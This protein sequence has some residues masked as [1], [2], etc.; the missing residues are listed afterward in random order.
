[1]LNLILIR[2]RRPL[3]INFNLLLFT[4]TTLENIIKDIKARENNGWITLL[5][6]ECRKCDTILLKLLNIWEYGK[7]YGEQSQEVYDFL[8]TIF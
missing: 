8:K 3:R 1:M 6:G 5:S 4:M 7:P 2:Q